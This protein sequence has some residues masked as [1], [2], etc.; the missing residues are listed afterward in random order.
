MVHNWAPSP[1]GN[2]KGRLK[3]IAAFGRQYKCPVL[4]IPQ[5]RAPPISDAIPLMWAQQHYSL[6]ARQRERFE[7]LPDD[8]NGRVGF[9]SIR[10]IRS[11]AA[12]HHSW[13]TMV[14]N[15]G[16]VILDQQ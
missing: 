13:I 11:A 8:D 6:Q 3:Q 16:R 14:E 10:H 15:P 5:L 4:P 1:L 2:Y 12:L 9:G 7:E